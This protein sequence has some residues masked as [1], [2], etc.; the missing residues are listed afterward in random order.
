MIKRAAAAGAVA[1]TAP[2]IIDSF[3][4]PAAAATFATGCY[5]SQA[6]TSPCGAAVS[7]RT[8]SAVPCHPSVWMPGAANG[9]AGVLSNPTCTG[10]NAVFTIP[11]DT[12]CVFVGG[13]VANSLGG[14][15]TGT[16]SAANKT[17]SFNA[18]ILGFSTATTAGFRM[19]ISCGGA[20]C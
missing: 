3:A 17:I 4:S 6:D 16:L 7:P 12:N 5:F 2:V 8:N 19:R 14:C 10:S 20:S 18:G 13:S 1:W 15:V 11:S 9:Y